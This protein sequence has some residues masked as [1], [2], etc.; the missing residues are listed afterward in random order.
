MFM[1]DKKMMEF[2]KEKE[3]VRKEVFKLLLS[4]A[5]GNRSNQE[6]IKTLNS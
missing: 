1:R 3:L 6:D 5:I 2:I 4:T